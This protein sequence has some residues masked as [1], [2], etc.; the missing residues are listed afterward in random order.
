MLISN[1]KSVVT[2]VCP[3]PFLRSVYIKFSQAVVSNL[4]IKVYNLFGEKLYT[5]SQQNPPL[6]VNIKLQDLPS[7]TYILLLTANNYAFSKTL[8]K[9]E[10]EESSFCTFLEQELL[11]KKKLSLFL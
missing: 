2:S 4:T 3:D 9:Q 6:I 10:S 7:G 5:E 1:N 11:S 8:I